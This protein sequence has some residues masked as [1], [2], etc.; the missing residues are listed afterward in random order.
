MRTVGSFIVRW[1]DCNLNRALLIAALYAVFAPATAFPKPLQI[2]HTND[3]HSH[4]EHGSAPGLGGYAQVK[5][6]I[7]ELRMQAQAQGIDVLQLD[8]GDFSEGS[9]F[10]LAKR[11]AVVWKVLDSMGYDA[12]TIGN[13]DWLLGP[14]DLDRVV[15]LTKPSFHFLGANFYYHADRKNLA[16]YMEPS[17]EFNRAG[18]KIGVLGLTTNQFLYAWRAEDGIIFN[19]YQTAFEQIDQLRSRNDYVIALTHM[20]VSAD[21][22]LAKRIEGIDLIVGGHSHTELR[23]PVVVKNSEGLQVPIV[24]VGQHGEFVGDLLVDVEPG[25]PLQILR[26]QLVPIATE[27]AKD[28]KID[29][30]VKGA[31]HSM[32]E[33]YGAE[34]LYEVVGQNEVP[35]EAPSSGHTVWGDIVDEAMMEAVGAELAV[36]QSQLFGDTQPPGPVTRERLFQFYPR[37]FDFDDKYG[38][39]IYTSKVRGWVLEAAIKAT[40]RFNVYL[41]FVGVTYDV[42]VKKG[43]KHAKN[44]KVGGQKIKLMKNYKVAFPEGIGRGAIEI[45]K[46]FKLIFKQTRNSKIPIWSAVEQKV[47][48]I[49]VV[50]DPFPALR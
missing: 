4:L 31:R 35:M 13:H 7:D 8:S 1:V 3:M 15:G 41:N 45:S 10:Y 24:Q 37:M 16:R 21:K 26:Y 6:K 20:G 14:G 22:K 39:N 46:A 32:E 30:L 23:E 50:K 17:A 42:V 47:R 33:D 43:K 11:G 5:A 18:V 34:W 12:V 25:K 19:P 44:I 2:I 28:S 36:D 29:D 27:G 38:W 40:V 49:G 9:Q 48:R